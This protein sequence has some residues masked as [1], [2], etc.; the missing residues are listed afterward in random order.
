[1]N[2]EE[3]SRKKNSI[4]INQMTTQMEYNN[5]L[6]M[7]V[8]SI[9][10]YDYGTSLELVRSNTTLI[11]AIE[12]M[13]T[14]HV[15]GEMDSSIKDL[16]QFLLKG[17]PRASIYKFVNDKKSGLQCGI[18]ISPENKRI[19]VVFR[20]T[21]SIRDLLC[22]VSFCKMELT[23]G[24]RVHR[25]F[26]QVLVGDTYRL[27]RTS[28]HELTT[29]YPHYSVYLSGHSL[30][31][32][33]ATL[34]A[35]KFVH[36]PMFSNVDMFHVISYGSPRI[37]NIGWR[38]AFNNNSRLSH[39]RVT[40]DKDIITVTPTWGF[41]HVGRE[42]HMDMS[43]V[44]VIGNEDNYSLLNRYSIND[45]YCQSYLTQAYRFQDTFDSI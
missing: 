41:Y 36:L 33:L 10:I 38:D 14:Y 11:D 20:G 31:G 45:H 17:D 18:T 35:Y 1:M 26:N 30:G 16:L 2:Q 27:I 22:D 3:A 37:G 28:L 6:G 42:V 12:M 24:V 25:G 39:L 4:Y 23:P 34:C 7:L 40:N 32:A 44:S 8:L 13:R 43:S 29:Q 21:E 19:C 9:L 5:I 15:N